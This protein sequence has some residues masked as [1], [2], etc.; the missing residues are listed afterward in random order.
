[1]HVNVQSGVGFGSVEPNKFDLSLG[2]ID[3]GIIL[4]TGVTSTLDIL[5]AR[6]GVPP[7]GTSIL[8]RSPTGEITQ[9]V[10]SPLIGAAGLLPGSLDANTILLMI[11]GAV[12]LLILLTK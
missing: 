8:Q 6:Y 4:Q 1:M 12:F 5:K 9:V 7:M 11:G 2:A 3:W 10:R